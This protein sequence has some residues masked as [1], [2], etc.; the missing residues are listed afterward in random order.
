[1]VSTV[2]ALGC[3]CANVKSRSACPGVPRATMPALLVGAAHGRQQHAVAYGG[4]RGKV[5]GQEERSA[6]RTAPHQ[7]ARNAAQIR[8]KAWRHGGFSVGG[9]GICRVPA[10]SAPGTSPW[11]RSRTTIVLICLSPVGALP[12]PIRQ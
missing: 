1:V 3:N 11:L 10:V 9:L 6:R 8:I 2:S 12:T 4:V 7:G 5:A